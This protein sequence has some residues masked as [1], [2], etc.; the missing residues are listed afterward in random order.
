MNTS[1]M[2]RNTL[3]WHW[4]HLNG[5]REVDYV[6]ADNG[7]NHIPFFYGTNRVKSSHIMSAIEKIECNWLHGQD[8]GT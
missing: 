7:S 4:Q 6:A 1:G 3:C 8:K 2:R 5:Q